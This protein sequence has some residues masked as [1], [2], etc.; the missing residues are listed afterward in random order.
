MTE[1]EYIL[2]AN[3]AKISTA[4]TIMRGVSPGNNYGISDDDYKLILLILRNSQTRLH[5]LAKTD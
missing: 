3:L 4:V 5:E 2:A 1:Q